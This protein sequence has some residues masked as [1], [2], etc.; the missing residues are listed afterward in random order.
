MIVNEGTADRIARLIVGAAALFGSWWLGFSSIGGIALLVVAGIG[1]VTGAVGY[2]PTY[3]LLKI[4]T[5]PSLH[6]VP[7][8]EFRVAAHH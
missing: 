7:T 6:R 2:C 3:Q 4:N 8:R 5:R 1:V